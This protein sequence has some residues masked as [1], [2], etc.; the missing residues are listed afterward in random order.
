LF[1]AATVP[2]VLL[3]ASAPFVMRGT[4]PKPVTATT[5]ARMPAVTLPLLFFKFFIVNL[6]NHS[7]NQ[8]IPQADWIIVKNNQNIILNVP[9]LNDFVHI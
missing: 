4:T 8:S 5:A 7:V 9:Q 2:E 3:P 1:V 6:P